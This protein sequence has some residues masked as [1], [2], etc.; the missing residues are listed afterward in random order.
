MLLNYI[1]KSKISNVTNDATREIHECISKVKI[2]PE[3]RQEYMLWEEKIFYERLDAKKEAMIENI[4]ELLEEYGSVPDTLVEKL[5][6]ESDLK[7]LK[8][9]LKLAAKVASIQQFMDNM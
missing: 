3:V 4:V 6:K 2:L 7:Q 8:I 5:N 1:Q 9:W